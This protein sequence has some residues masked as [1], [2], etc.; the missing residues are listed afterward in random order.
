M[1]THR[2][3]VTVIWLTALTA[4][5][6]VPLAL[7]SL[8]T[9]RGTKYEKVTI[10]DASV[11]GVNITHMNG[12]ARLAWRD[13]P[14]EI[15]ERLQW[16]DERIAKVAEAKSLVS[17]V[18]AAELTA[19]E[20]RAR[21]AKR[22]IKP[23]ELRFTV[24]A[25]GKNGSLGLLD[26]REAFLLGV[27][28]HPPEAVVT[29]MGWKDGFIKMD[30]KPVPQIVLENPVEPPGHAEAVNLLANDGG[31]K[32]SMEVKIGAVE[33][34]QTR[35]RLRTRGLPTTVIQFTV[36]EVVYNGVLGKSTDGKLVYIVG[37]TGL[38]KEQNSTVSAWPD[39]MRIV[40]G[41]SYQVW[42]TTGP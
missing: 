5:A 35:D 3:L 32:T 9:P 2:I 27:V 22:K 21:L 25:E 37:A 41:V 29:G 8:E 28:A 30:G 18:K 17:L 34:I 11:D 38:A 7:S 36:S 20:A 16:T 40:G 24:R 6:Q 39:G 33:T 10:T 42:V 31:D 13:V 12:L 19:V 15:R 1:N 14:Q 4:R 23:L 26:G